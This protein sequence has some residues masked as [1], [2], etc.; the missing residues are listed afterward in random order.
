MINKKIMMSGVSIVAALSMM[1]GSAF[2]L[3]TSSASN[4]G[5]VLGAGNLVLSI[6][7]QAPISTGVF[8]VSSIIPGQSVTQTLTLKNEGSVDASNI[9][10]QGID[11]NGGTLGPALNMELFLDNN[12]DGQVDV[13]DTPLGGPAALNSGAWT[14][15]STGLPLPA[16]QFKNVLVRIT[17]DSNADNSF[18]GANVNFDINLQAN[19]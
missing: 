5:N 10:V 15:Y 8:N 11:I 12:N 14:G 2:A 16:G 4:N 3:F 9:I 18:Q 17:F 7:T 19:Q 1:T 6:N 13:G